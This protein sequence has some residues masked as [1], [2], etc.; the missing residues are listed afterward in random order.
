MSCE[1][2][3]ETRASWRGGV[4]VPEA[5]GRR[6][7]SI[8]VEC[9][10]VVATLLLEVE[11]DKVVVEKKMRLSRK[12]FQDFLVRKLFKHRLPA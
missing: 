9:I 7:T 10:L 2:K 12:A 6:E 8:K 11:V 5:I 3:G 4:V 1:A